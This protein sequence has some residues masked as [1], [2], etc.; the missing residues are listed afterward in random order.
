MFKPKTKSTIY[1]LPCFLAIFYLCIGAY[2]AHP[3]MHHH[4]E[5][6]VVALLPHSDNTTAHSDTAVTS[7][8]HHSHSCL[9]CG[10][11]KATHSALLCA[12]P[13]ETQS[14]ALLSLC[15]RYH[16]EPYSNSHGT[17]FARGPPC[18]RFS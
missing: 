10:F 9:V 3:Y 18:V 8:D 2:I 14:Q 16:L 7:S 5:C 12:V 13:L 11:L 1:L 17:P 6:D 15:Y 4:E